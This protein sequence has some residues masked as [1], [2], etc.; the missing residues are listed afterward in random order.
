MIRYIDIKND[1]STFSTYRIITNLQLLVCTR[2]VRTR[3]QTGC[4]SAS[5]LWT[6][7]QMQFLMS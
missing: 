3:P 7:S 6:R 5:S 2:D 4:T 1:I